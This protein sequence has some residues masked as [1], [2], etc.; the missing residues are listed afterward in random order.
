MIQNKNLNTPI[1][2]LTTNQLG[3]IIKLTMEKNK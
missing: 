2:C 1:K 3:S